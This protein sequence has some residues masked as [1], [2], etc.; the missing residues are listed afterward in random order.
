MIT[1]TGQASAASSIKSPLSRGAFEY[2]GQKLGRLLNIV[3]LWRIIRLFNTMV[4]GEQELH[5]ETKEKLEMAQIEIKKLKRIY[6][7]K[8]RETIARIYLGRMFFSFQKYVQCKPF[9]KKAS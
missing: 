1:S 3:K 8:K 4:S 6:T 2:Q 9:L 5:E 7:L